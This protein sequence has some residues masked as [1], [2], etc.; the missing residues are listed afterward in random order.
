MQYNKRS[1]QKIN[2]KK[3]MRKVK[4]Q[5]VVLSVSA[6]AALGASAFFMFNPDEVNVHADATT[7]KS[8]Q[9]INANG[10]GVQSVGRPNSANQ[11]V[12][13]STPNEQNQGE[14]N[15]TP[16][17]NKKSVNQS[18]QDN[19]AVDKG[20]QINAQDLEKYNGDDKSSVKNDQLS[21]SKVSAQDNQLNDNKFAISSKIGKDQLTKGSSVQTTSQP[22][23]DNSTK[24]QNDWNNGQKDT[25]NNSN[26][27]KNTYN[28]SANG[29][30]DAMNN[31][32]KNIVQS[33]NNN[34]PSNPNPS[35]TDPGYQNGVNQYNNY[36]NVMNS[37]ASDAYNG[38]SD[39]S[40][41]QTDAT[42]KNY[43][44][45]AYNGVQNARN[46]YNNVTQNEGTSNQDYTNYKQWISDNNKDQTDTPENN[47]NNVSAY[48]NSLNDKLN[49]KGNVSV[50]TNANGSI[51][52]AKPNDTAITNQQN[53]YNQQ[54][55]YDN[56]SNYALAYQYGINYFLANQGAADA[57]SGKWN[58]SNGA[59]TM[60]S[61]YNPDNKSTNPYDQAY[62]GAKAAINKQINQT[63]SGNNTQVNNYSGS[64]SAL[65]QSG[66]N[67]AA[68]QTQSGTVYIGNA[69][70]MDN[71]LKNDMNNT[72]SLKLVNDIA[73]QNYKQ[74]SLTD[75]SGINSSSLDIDGQNHILDQTDT[76]YTF[77]PQNSN[78][79]LTIHNFQT[80]YG[81][82]Y[83]GPFSFDNYGSD[84]KANTYG[85]TYSN[86]NY[87]GS[88]LLSS[89]YSDVYVNGNVNQDDVDTYTSP[90]NS[91]ATQTGGNAASGGYGNGG[92]YQPGLQINNMVLGNNSNYF[93]NSAQQT[94]GTTL[95]INGNLTL[96][97]GSNMTLMPTGAAEGQ[98][99]PDKDGNGN[100]SNYGINITNSD[101]SI[102]V[103]KNATLNI[104]PQTSY[105]AHVSDIYSKGSIN[106]NGGT[107]NA[108][109]FG[110]TTNGKNV[111]IYSNGQVNILNGGSLNVKA[112][113]MS[114]SNGLINNNANM[115]VNS[116]GSL[117]VDGK[118]T[119]GIVNLIS[120][121]KVNVYDVGDKNVNLLRNNN[122]NSSFSTAG[123]NGYT[124]RAYTDPNNPD[125]TWY[126]NFD[127]NNS[128][129]YT[130][131]DQN[132]STKTGNITAQSLYI[133]AVPAARFIG[134][135]YVTKDKNNNTVI[136]GYAK[137]EQYS[138]NAGPVYIQYVGGN[139][140]GQNIPQ[141]NEMHTIGNPEISN[142]FSS[143]D[144]DKYNQQ[145]NISGNED[146]IP[147]S[148][149]V[150]AGTPNY[151]TFGIRVRYGVSGV[152]EVT[153][154]NK[155]TSNVEGR[156]QSNNGLVENDSVLSSGS[157]DNSNQGLNN[158]LD[159]LSNYTN[160][161]NS[162]MYQKDADY[163]NSYD[164]AQAG[165]K[166]YN[167]NPNLGL[168]D[169]NT[170]NN[171]LSNTS[172][173]EY[174]S[175]NNIL[176]NVSDPGSFM[177]G[178]ARAKADNEGH[179]DG[180]SS[181]NNNGY[182]NADSSKTV[183]YKNNYNTSFTFAMNGF[184]DAL[185]SS[186]KLP[187]PSGNANDSYNAGYNEEQNAIN[188]AN[189]AVQNASSNVS[190]QVNSYQAGFNAYNQ[191]LNDYNVKHQ[192]SD[193]SSQPPLY[194]KMYN[195]QFNT[196]SNDV[197]KGIND[198][199]NNPSAGNQY[200][201]SVVQKQ[202]Y[203][204]TIAGT[205]AQANNSKKPYNF[206][207][208]S[209]IYQNAYNNAYNRAQQ[210]AASGSNL[211]PAQQ[212][213]NANSA[214][215]VKQATLDAAANDPSK[216]A[217]YQGN[218]NADMTYQGAQAGYSNGGTNK[219]DPAKAGNSYYQNAFNEAQRKA[220]QAA[221]NGVS[222]FQNGASNTPNESAP[223]EK[224]ADSYGY[225]QAQ[226]GYNA[227]NKGTVDNSNNDPSYKAGVQI[228][229]EAAKGISDAQ[230]NPTQ[231]SSY[232]GTPTQADAY[233]ATVAGS[234][235]GA[236]GNK[237]PNLTGKSRA[238]QDA[239]KNAYDHAK[240][241]AD[242]AAAGQLNENNLSNSL[243]RN[244]FA[245]GTDQA[246]EGYNAALANDSKYSGNSNSDLAYQGARDG[247]T[248]GKQH[249][250]NPKMN[251]PVY[252]NAYKEAQS[253]A[254]KAADTGSQ[255]F[256]KP[257][258]SSASG[259]NDALSAAQNYGYNQAQAGYEDQKNNKPNPN[260]SNP[261]YL[262]GIQYAKDTA[263]ARKAAGE[264]GPSGTQ[265]NSNIT[266][267]D[268]YI[269]SIDGTS[270][271][272][273]NAPKKSYTTKQKSQMYIDSYNKAY[274]SAHNLA[275]QGAS[276]VPEPT[277]TLND[278][279]NN[280]AY[281][282]G[283]NDYNNAYHLA[284][285]QN[286]PAN[287]NNH[288][289]NS[290]F[291]EAYNGS[292]A[293]FS[294]A[295]KGDTNNPTS[296]NV[297]YIR[298]YKQ[299]M[300]TANAAIQQG[301]G[302]FANGDNQSSTA[303][304]NNPVA[305]A[306]NNAYSEAM[307]GYNAN[308]VDNQ[309][310]N[311][312]YQAGVKMKNDMNSGINAANSAT[313]QNP[314]YSEDSAQRQAYQATFAATNAAMHGQQKP[315]LTGQSRVYQD[316]YNQ[317]YQQ[318]ESAMSGDQSKLTPAQKQAMND[319]KNKV[320]AATNAASNDDQSADSNYQG[321]DNSSRA[322]QGAK[323]GYANGGNNKMDSSQ[324]G[325]PYYNQAFADAQKKAQAAANNGSNQ[326][327]EGKVNTPSEATPAEQAADKY[328]YDQAQAGYEAANNGT[329]DSSNADP[330]YQAGVQAAKDIN[331]GT[332]DAENNPNQGNNYQ[333]TD[334]QKKAYQATTDAT[335]AAMNGQAKPADLSHQS[336]SYQAAYNKAYDKAKTIA[337][338]IANGNSN[339]S[340]MS[341]L[342]QSASKQANDAVNNAIDAAKAN[343]PANDQKYQGNDNA[344]MAYQGAKA[345]FANN[346]N[347]DL[348]EDNS[349][350][351][352]KD[353]FNK[354]KQA[355]QDAS[356][357][358]AQEYANGATKS[359]T[360]GKTDA[361][362][363][364]H[365]NGYN[366]IQNG[367][368]DQRRN[369][370]DPDNSDPS[371]VKGIQLAKDESQGAADAQKVTKPD[372]SY[373]GSDAQKQAYQAT[374]D[375]IKAGANSGPKPSDL[376]NQSRAYQDA[377]NA[378]YNQAQASANALA[379]GGPNTNL[380]PAE[381]AVISD[382]NNNV[383][384][385]KD[386]AADNN[387][388]DDINYQG[389]TNS[390]M[391]YQGAKSG[392]AN[393]GTGTMDP[394]KV[395]N[396]FYR[397]SFND[398]QKKAQQAAQAG[399]KQFNAG[400]NNVPNETTPAEQAANKYGYD[401]AQAGYNDQNDGKAKTNNADPA[402]Q[403]GVQMAKNVTQGIDDAE[404][405]PNQG[406]S[407]QG[408]DAQKQ[409]YQGTIDA[410][411][412]NGGNI[413]LSN[414]PKAYQ[415]AYNK[416]LKQAQSSYENG[417]DQFNNDQP[418]SEAN[419]DKATAIA[420]N[421]G[422]RAAQSI[423]NQVLKDPNSVDSSNL[424]P[425]QKVG[426]EKAQQAI[427][428]LKDYAS[429]KQPT[430]TD[431]NYMAG[432]NTA[433]QAAQ[434][435]MNDVRN[436][437][438]VQLNNVPSGMNPQ[439]YNDVYNATYSGYNNGY[440]GNSNKSNQG[441][442]YNIAYQ[443]AYSQGQYD[444]P[445]ASTPQ[446]PQQKNTNKPNRN[447]NKAANNYA[448]VDQNTNKGIIDAINGHK[449]KFSS[450]KPYKN[451]FDLGKE[452]L[453]GMHAAEYGRKAKQHINSINKSFYMFGYNGYKSGVR[454]AKRTL[455]ANK[456][457]GKHD[458]A[459]KSVAYVYAYRQGEK[460]EKRHQHN[461]GTKQGIA[462]AKKGHAIPTSLSM[463]HSAQY[464]ES[465]V[466]AYK[467]TMKRNM[468]KYVY[469]V[470]TIFV[471]KQLKF[472]KGNRVVRYVK[473]PRY[474]AKL[475]RVTGIA[476]YKNDIPRYRVVGGGMIA[477]KH[478]TGVIADNGNVVNAY[479][480]HN[481]KYFKVIK[482]KGTLTYKGMKFTK[483][484]KSHKVYHGEIFKVDKVV[485]YHGLT[486]FYIGHGQ[487]ITSNKTIVQKV[488]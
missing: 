326:F 228:A 111:L 454:A 153:S 293:G 195:Y 20:S 61:F 248:D 117:T 296:Q 131:T 177:K 207:K 209:P 461:L 290:N 444:I 49:S 424:D 419:D 139:T 47:K 389:N 479:Y 384:T 350:P 261:N 182:K 56:N 45:S 16:Q 71:V 400:Q 309:D 475:L 480:R 211:T 446:H 314:D 187:N 324:E 404:N 37:G 30:K 471:H 38:K 191:A 354:A 390:D 42:N 302:E 81:A 140:N 162:T 22:S 218:S 92:D 342:E 219:M 304:Q 250:N 203:E 430:N 65:Y 391:A 185:N 258:A 414:K 336:I 353:A 347:N 2:E 440:T 416:A 487:Y 375:G 64:N 409:A 292:I 279:L 252:A 288:N 62:L 193:V 32:N 370:V 220:Q 262:Q 365:N 12:K 458:L 348:P 310:N 408:S 402:Y 112:S 308:P 244:S 369:N 477:D 338:K 10:S 339:P 152:N 450:T 36:R 418:N 431:S 403:A 3:I 234:N 251:D 24:A 54:N 151:D 142:S 328:G 447:S 407:Y 226:A 70:Q 398:A 39:N 360:Q 271:G 343:D 147:I 33:Q 206:D 436:G 154:N 7:T 467:R 210:A 55:G 426:Y 77:Y 69:V 340:G 345:G 130:G 214:A 186:K 462:M 352:Y 337:D 208:Q 125:N 135:I 163:T 361:I 256:A 6:F 51:Q 215:N 466:K 329:D 346:G 383:T 40:S 280:Q 367:Y 233:N 405:N 483:D 23:N 469:N 57:K 358:G 90:F 482:P 43:Y 172:S 411:K 315:N 317:A 114:N 99:S 465:Y 240:G 249:L 298:A 356:S 174:S 44:E 387:S 194:Q 184:Q 422:Y 103:N 238:Y 321:T 169:Q 106:V 382:A 67:D 300:N 126:Y 371:Y 368:T 265:T 84:T 445:V 435:A 295:N 149:T 377:Y 291:D 364:A 94:G 284:A 277:S 189:L 205:N 434:A 260:N 216:A 457:L 168:N 406:N 283:V 401:Q 28:N 437:K 472:D 476:Y 443:N 285:N 116:G 52:V 41:L 127:M 269:G 257:I 275:Y 21:G 268:G 236:S 254:A 134:P 282:Q 157:V 266:Q 113:N 349:N 199:Q 5:W 412:N 165:Y 355:A 224:Q 241:I 301:I 438:A 204:A 459:G 95:E 107:I 272:A 363:V 311:P 417:I 385:A 150:P 394:A 75:V 93:S 413:D 393:G 246:K 460:V 421:N 325:N 115:N 120:G 276:G 287:D 196:I 96:G 225:N 232:Q 441:F 190:G 144:T 473:V 19:T 13:T 85:M 453:K 486:R 313:T 253:A 468:P 4:K 11:S 200:S 474:K 212:A 27:Y 320:N 335:Q 388:A 410:Y 231:G 87:V 34:T 63:Q 456:R 178:Y 171:I 80:I 161:R 485:K 481:F 46:D 270:D 160:D 167:T 124:V 306:H 98:G 239:Y 179:I 334:A 137:V 303:G 128:G 97:E 176:T 17:L 327:I 278:R 183:A 223:A 399:I 9:S 53:Q 484:N 132:G 170:I 18:T 380:S 247:F 26:D 175:I 344:S 263:D 415:D 449:M 129:Q 73:F 173:G 463:I 202:A 427:K 235:D 299:A 109:A 432:Y 451:G 8:E 322:Y 101:A 381:K 297:V 138:K 267:T 255:E 305:N 397:N 145:V 362:S 448:N 428:G 379:N 264:T 188:G 82:N 143:I 294:A 141:Y 136:N 395:N 15:S 48:S 330:S 58:G 133:S 230:N 25:D 213:A 119:S 439:L 374:F 286:N 104:Y 316:A 14:S 332:N 429:G 281:T 319:N 110:N 76:N 192:A 318:T 433:K 121:N 156:S 83:Y 425:A 323:A 420:H 91:M 89:Y 273:T 227:Q 86:I 423:Y 118:N 237:Q 59:N 79:K 442:A 102:N 245:K 72:N 373:S 181:F 197:N 201:G 289:S 217:N 29:F 60:K 229:S 50:H 470:R 341:N 105:G 88:K 1:I 78:T 478:G 159:D 146:L 396:P 74:W 68:K 242:R 307:K 351:Y 66:Y 100:G 259:Q 333:G 455:K 158:S 312:G 123:I 274:D 331:K 376:S 198:A 221:Q 122:S 366:Q 452:A 155:Y 31:D 464:V 372:S 35:K 488:G 392:Y 386:K 357:K 166:L 148:F 378:A 180:A 243:D 164:S 359:S 108:E 222:Q